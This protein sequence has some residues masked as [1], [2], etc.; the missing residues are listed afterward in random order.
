MNLQPKFRKFLQ[1][2]FL[3]LEHCSSNTDTMLTPQETRLVSTEQLNSLIDTGL[4]KKNHDPKTAWCN[5]CDCVCDV[6]TKD[7]KNFLICF[8]CSNFEVVNDI[9][10]LQYSTSLS[11]LAKFLQNTLESQND[12]EIIDDNRLFYLGYKEKSRYYFFYGI[13]QSDSQEMLNKVSG[14]QHTFILTL[15]NNYSLKIPHTL[16]VYNVI[17]I[18]YLQ[19]NKFSLA[20]PI[21]I[22]KNS[23][24]S[25][26]GNAKSRKYD[27]ARNFI[28]TEYN[29]LLM[30]EDSKKLT[31]QKLYTKIAN[32][33]RK[34]PN[35]IQ[36]LKDENLED[37]IRKT[38]TNKK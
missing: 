18:L 1:I 34:K 31:K 36:G 33:L 9:N 7:L 22:Y 13:Q 11:K 5:H 25:V 17:D 20:L 15:K 29:K 35:L 19:N 26:G 27:N 3:R 6:T 32:M 23:I 37:Y 16:S 10:S 24:S 12:I 28:I 14:S 38:I 4:I 8:E 30:I 2:L 21:T